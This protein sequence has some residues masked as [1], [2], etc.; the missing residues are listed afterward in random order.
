MMDVVDRNTR[1]RMMSGIKSK[2]TKPELIIRSLLHKSGFRY[3][4]HVKD[5]PGK[6]DLVL[7]K[8]KAV[9]FVHGCFWHMH[10]C[11]YFKWPKSHV[12]F[13]K[14]KIS[15]NHDNDRKNLVKLSNL[16]WRVCVIWECSIRDAKD[17][18]EYIKTEIETW[19]ISEKKFLEVKS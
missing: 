16:G 1:S 17:D 7:K 12:N 13:W 19:L 4:L 10:D 14:E 18:M 6:P 8:Y 11:K 3:R 15:K 2:N 9:I 5:L